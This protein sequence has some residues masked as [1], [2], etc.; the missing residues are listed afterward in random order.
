LSGGHVDALA[1]IL[2]EHGLL[3]DLR[4][5]PGRCACGWRWEPFAHYPVAAHRAHVAQVL[6]DWVAEREA[7]AARKALDAVER[8]IGMSGFRFGDPSAHAEALA[9][10]REC[11]NHQEAHRG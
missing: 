3:T 8:T 11:R 7:Q 2:A 1:G 10:V 4:G 9:I 5:R 6:A